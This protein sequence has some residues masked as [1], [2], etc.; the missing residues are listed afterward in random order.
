MQAMVGEGR[1]VCDAG[2]PGGAE[3]DVPRPSVPLFSDAR[4]TRWLHGLK[5]HRAEAVG[6]FAACARTGRWQH[7]ACRPDRPGGRQAF[8][9]VTRRRDPVGVLGRGLRDG[10]ERSAPRGTASS[11]IDRRAGGSCPG[12]KRALDLDFLT[13]PV[14]GR[15]EGSGLREGP[16]KEA[17]F[18]HSDGEN[19][20]NSAGANFVTKAAFFS[21]SS[22]RS[23]SGK[24]SLVSQAGSRLT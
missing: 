11:G 9:G 12:A 17:A 5:G 15:T 8:C 18:L 1:L 21:M 13:R 19:V 24:A 4:P 16:E 2:H 3:G 23:S 14:G 10:Q 7:A 22:F 6:S 20:V